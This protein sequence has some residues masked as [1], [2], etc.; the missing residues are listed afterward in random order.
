MMDFA[1]PQTS[2]HSS[3]V[4][5]LVP[6]VAGVL[7]LSDKDIEEI[8]L[9]ARFHDIGKVAVPAEVLRKPG[10]L[11]ELERELMAC[12]VEWGAELLR[13]LPDCGAIAHIVRH[14]HERFD[15]RG[16]PDGLTGGDIPLGSRII[17]A[18]DAYGAMISD[19]PYRPALAEERAVDELVQGAGTQFDPRAV[20]AV[21]RVVRRPE[22]SKTTAV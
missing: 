6:L 8:E 2:E 5:D 15:G 14:H 16:Y 22:R 1:D 11:D 18:C 17:A 10:P 13:H 4:A 3:D 9:A 7:G 12:H 20:A 21:L 19:R